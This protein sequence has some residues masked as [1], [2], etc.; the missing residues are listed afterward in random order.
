M[1]IGLTGGIGS[2]KTTVSDTLRQLGCIVLDADA[3]YKE[4]TEEG[5]PLVA[6]LVKEFGDVLTDG[7]LDR[8]KLSKVAL[9]NPRL[10]EI[11]H[12]AISKEIEAR[13]KEAGESDVYL[14]MPLLFEAGYDAKV[15]KIWLVTAPLEERIKRVVI[16]DSIEKE[17]ILKRISLQISE[18]EKMKKADVVI[19]NDASLE[20]LIKKVKEL[21]NGSEKDHK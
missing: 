21:V 11:T 9:G 15:D 13:I 3:I 12:K 19:V 18:E 10:N 16:R 20:E 7:K 5:K 17:E 6:E 1:I 4:L 14:D 8:K 2:G